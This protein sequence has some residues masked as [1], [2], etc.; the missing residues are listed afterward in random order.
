MVAIGT[1]LV[2]NESLGQASQASTAPQ[3]R[4]RLITWVSAAARNRQR[5]KRNRRI[6]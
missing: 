3:A 5:I 6:C 4:T 2:A 1:L